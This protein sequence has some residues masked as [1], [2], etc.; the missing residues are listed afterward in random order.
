MVFLSSRISPFASTVIFWERSPLAMAVEI[1]G[2]VAHLG[3]EVAREPIDAVG[4]LLPHAGDAPDVGL[5][6]ELALGTDL[7][8]DADDLGRE[9]AQLIDGRV[10]GV[11]E[12]EDLSPR[13]DGDLL[14]EVALGDGGRDQ[15]DVAHLGGQVAGQ[16][17]DVVDEVLPG[18]REAFDAG[19]HAELAFAAHFANDPRDTRRDGAEPLHHGVDGRSQAGGIRLAAVARPGGPACLSRDPPS[20]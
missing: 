11:L 15:G 20:R 9:R 12:L 5:R 7:A 8:G 13:L 3:S 6:A 17:V 4:E 16:R 19:L 18:A 1:D 14:G 10:D 2:D